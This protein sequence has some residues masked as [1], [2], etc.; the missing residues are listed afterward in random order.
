MRHVH[1]SRKK[2]AQPSLSQ[3]LYRALAE[4][5]QAANSAQPRFQLRIRLR[6]NNLHILY[7][8]PNKPQQDVLVSRLV[9]AL[10][11]N[12]QRFQE[13]TQG[14]KAPIYKLILYGRPAGQ[15]NP[16]WVEPLDLGQ[17]LRPDENGVN[18]AMPLGGPAQMI[19]NETL[20]RTGNPDA[21]ARYLSENFSYLGVSIK[22][23]IKKLPQI[24]PSPDPDEP[25]ANKRLWVICSCDYSPDASLL[26]KPIAQK[27]RDLE[28]KGFREAVIRSQVSGETTPDWVLQIDL[29][30]PQVMLYDW[31]RW[32]DTEAL[33]RLIDQAVQPHNLQGG[34]ILKDST[35]HVFC[36]FPIGHSA[37]KVDREVVIQAVGPLLEKIAPQGIT[38]ATIY[39]VR[40]PKYSLNLDEAP[41]WIEWLNLAA[42]RQPERAIATP[43]LAKQH[44]TEALTFLLQRLLNPELDTR[45]ATGGYGVKLCYKDRRLH[46]MT[47]GL[48]CPDQAEVVP[49]LEDFLQEL[50]IPNLLG[51]RIYGRRAGQSQPVWHHGFEMRDAVTQTQPITSTLN[52]IATPSPAGV[53]IA[54]E[55]AT[56]ISWQEVAA[57]YINDFCCSTRLFVPF[58]QEAL[59]NLTRST[60]LTRSRRATSRQS[61]H[62]KTAIACG[63]AGVAIATQ[64]DWLTGRWLDNQSQLPSTATSPL[65][66]SLTIPAQAAPSEEIV[67]PNTTAN[68]GTFNAE[69]FTNR[70]T[71]SATTAAILA[72]A[73]ASN[74]TFNNR[75]LDEKLALYQERLRTQGV[76][77]VL[78]VGSSRAMRGIDP[79]TLQLAL[80]QQGYKDV[81]IFNFGINGATAQVVDLILR[82]ILTPEQLPNLIIWADGARAF[83]SGRPDRTYEAILSSVGYQQLQENR[84]IVATPNTANNSKS[85]LTQFDNQ[86]AETYNNI[87]QSLNMSLAS[88]LN[89]YDR[90]TQVK[91]LL[92][93]TWGDWLPQPEVDPEQAAMLAE[94]TYTEEIDIDGFLPLTVRFEPQTY[95]ERHPRVKGAYD[96]DYESFALQGTQAQSLQAVTQFLSDR[97]INLVLINLPLT[98]DYLD[99]VR[100]SYEQDF[101]AYL[102]S[103]A[104]QTPLI[105]LDWGQQWTTQH[106]LYSDPSHLN[107]YGAYQ[108]STTLAQNKAIPWPR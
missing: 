36:N 73:R 103:Q 19:A 11:S 28:L 63:I 62:L 64:M 42:S 12:P 47:E 4:E 43:H 23:V 98:D 80:A 5:T 61:R 92:R 104:A 33:S 27:L 95:Y 101:V 9:Q 13:L 108:V 30:R 79:T 8:S 44:N 51:V 84:D 59:A 76:P 82:R 107:R 66:N 48:I 67:L 26:A 18:T 102:Q 56:S 6:G 32:G 93:Q 41:I 35:L 54:P 100:L 78:I 85:W 10:Q 89:T 38:A 15:Q 20:A 40:S 50:A 57:S 68:D 16:V 58:D 74:P 39:G 14:A 99:E 105:F 77:D 81:E 55:K 97:D 65:E 25:A 22:V 90:R 37:E 21:I 2:T 45:L 17:L 3:W 87:D 72:N 91:A 7:E 53:A 29:T 83:N 69:Q 94:L 106:D 24:K 88:I 86:I 75:L 34:A 1:R 60:P 96:S 46:I 70:E 31:A 49:L 52:K 71:D